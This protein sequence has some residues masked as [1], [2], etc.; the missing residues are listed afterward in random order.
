MQLFS[1]D[2]L[3]EQWVV[4]RKH[5]GLCN[6]MVIIPVIEHVA[7]RKR[8]SFMLQSFRSTEWKFNDLYDF[9]A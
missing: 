9:V 4:F 7:R 5:G 1:T 6:P 2:S 3:H 8:R